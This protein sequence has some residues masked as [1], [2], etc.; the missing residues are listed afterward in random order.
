VGFDPGID[1]TAIGD[2]YVLLPK[3]GDK[4]T[5]STEYWDSCCSE[6]YNAKVAGPLRLGDVGE[7]TN[8]SPAEASSTSVLGYNVLAPNGVRWRYGAGQVLPLIGE[9]KC[10]LP[11]LI[12]VNTVGNEMNQLKEVCG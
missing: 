3:V 12:K 1:L 7:V 4:V 9:I 6:E 11:G 5:L 10:S 8:V 2:D